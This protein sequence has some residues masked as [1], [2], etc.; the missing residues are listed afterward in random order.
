M[1]LVALAGIPYEARLGRA[2]WILGLSVPPVIALASVDW[3]CG[4]S[5]LSHAL[6]AGALTY[7]ALRRRG[8]TRAVVL[9]LCAIAA[10]KPLYEVV[11]GAS[12]FPMALGAHVVDV[13]L[14]HATGVLIGIACV[15]ARHL[16]C[17]PSGQPE[18]ES[19]VRC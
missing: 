4:L 18:E 14:A 7:E 8:R 12:A 9:V 6:L 5:C 16:A 1:A 19:C 2:I 13:P 10:L 17:T 11:T 15:F 3:Y